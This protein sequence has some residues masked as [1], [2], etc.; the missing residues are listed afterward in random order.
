MDKKQIILDFVNWNNE[1]HSDYIPNSRIGRYLQEIKCESKD[2]PDEL[3]NCNKPHVTGSDYKAKYEKCL[4]VIKRF[5][6]GI[7]GMYDL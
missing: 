3:G 1:N 7:I 2:S 6:A 5:D 4:K